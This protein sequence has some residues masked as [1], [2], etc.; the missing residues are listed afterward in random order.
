M[1]PQGPNDMR[2]WQR[3]DGSGSSMGQRLEFL[4]STRLLPNSTA[5]RNRSGRARG[6]LQRR[7][8]HA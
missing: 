7:V 2:R 4:N 3:L 5:R 8:E 6:P 1:L